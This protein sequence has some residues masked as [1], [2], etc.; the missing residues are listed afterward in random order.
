MATPVQDGHCDESKAGA[1]R[2]HLMVPAKSNR[3]TVAGLELLGDGGTSPS[4]V[5][6]IGSARLE[7]E[8]G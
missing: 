6:L 5:R 7:G 1:W 2:A 3:G 8:Q 4:Q